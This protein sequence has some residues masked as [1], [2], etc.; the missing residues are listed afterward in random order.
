[1]TDSA[2]QIASDSGRSV[3]ITGQAKVP[4]FGLE[5][6]GVDGTGCQ[7]DIATREVLQIAPSLRIAS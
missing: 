7:H 5:S 3:S 1:M 2:I 6:M 4:N